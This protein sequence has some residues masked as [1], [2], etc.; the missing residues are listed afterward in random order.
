MC[1]S[2][3][4]VTNHFANQ[5][6]IVHENPTMDDGKTESVV[7]L[8]PLFWA[9]ALWLWQ[10]LWESDRARINY[11]FDHLSQSGF[12][13]A[14]G[15]HQ[16]LWT[17]YMA[18]RSPNLQLGKGL[19]LSPNNLSRFKFEI[20]NI[21]RESQT[22]HLQANLFVVP[23]FEPPQYCFNRFSPQLFYRL[24]AN[25]GITPPPS[26]ARDHVEKSPHNARYCWKHPHPL[27]WVAQEFTTCIEHL[28]CLEHGIEASPIGT[29]FRHLKTLGNFMYSGKVAHKTWLE[30]HEPTSSTS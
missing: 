18:G 4:S 13:A 24:C 26:I 20:M 5:P 21:L 12:E 10:R 7:P 15:A 16:Q 3:V 22:N 23:T 29:W 25:F 19:P 1:G 17:L 6:G 8:A 27:Q 30:D 11:Q 2:T 9:V 14:G 28:E